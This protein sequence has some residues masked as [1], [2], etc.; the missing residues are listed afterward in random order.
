F[1]TSPDG[2][3][4]NG[5]TKYVIVT[6][7]KGRE[8][9]KY[10]WKNFNISH[11]KDHYAVAY[12]ANGGKAKELTFAVSDQLLRWKKVVKEDSITESGALV[13]NLQYKHRYVLYFGEKDIRVAY[14]S[15]LESWKTVTKPVLQ[16]RPGFF[17][18][19]DIEIA[20]VFI[21]AEQILVIYYAKDKDG[22]KTHYHVGAA[23]F[24]CRNPEKMLWR[25]DKPLWEQT[26]HQHTD[27]LKPLGV[28]LMQEQ[29]ILYWTL[30]D[31][32]MY[33]VSCPLP[34]K[35]LRDK[36]VQI[37]LKKPHQNPI[38][39]PRT[40]H[41]WESRAVFNSAALYEDGK[42][43]FLYRALGE[44]D[45]SVI[46]YA[47]SRD[48]INIDERSEEP[49]YLPREPF[50]TPGGKAFKSFADHFASGGGY[51]GIEDPR[52]TKIDD[53]VY[54][55]YVAFDGY[56]E[57]RAALT[58]IPLEDFLKKNWGKWK[59]PKLISPPGM[60]NKS[61][62]IFPEKINGKY[63]VIHRV[64]PNI[65][66]DV[67][68]DLNFDDKFL[69]GHHFIPP[70]KG[71]WDSKKIGA[72]APP[73]L[74]KDGWLLIYQSVG[75][76]DPS[77]Y[78]IGAMVLDKDDP[79]KVLYR[80]NNPIVS[81][82]MPYDNDGFKAG[83]VYPCG[84]VIKDDNLFVYYGGADTIVAAA[85]ENIDTFLDKMKNHKEPKLKRVKGPV[86]AGV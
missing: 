63:V 50:E 76:Q 53:M 54:M 15:Q 4:F 48:G 69:T 61:A 8:D 86:F 64:Y 56:S 49:I 47:T 30:N 75:H 32:R 85:T 41:V 20:K 25:T 81:P 39:K 5:S 11:H 42:V 29:L 66:I 35:S 31:A 77:R 82:D 40:S 55:T 34:G 9:T 73:M 16:S 6:D 58:S 28:A 78:K 18:E 21:Q 83:V 36:D 70:R 37:L 57:P 22:D 10:D 3:E 19:G 84:A 1:V 13:P 26:K 52:V 38:I 27:P 65:L 12:K 72:G 43:H 23:Y 74:T 46:G 62:V 79:S 67:L 80:T 14:S 2:F 17:D 24:D 59:T 44:S 68:D 60:V 33:A 71:H 51:G 45:L 7:S